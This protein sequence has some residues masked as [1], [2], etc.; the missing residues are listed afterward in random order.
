MLAAGL[1]A[2]ADHDLRKQVRRLQVPTLVMAGAD[3]P[4]VPRSLVEELASL[5]PGARMVVVPDAGH[6]PNRDRPEVF[7]EALTAFVDQLVAV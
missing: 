4:V 5:I 2:L 7:D 3:D 6:L 1:V